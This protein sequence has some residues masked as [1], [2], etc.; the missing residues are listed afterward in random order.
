[1][2]DVEER[3]Q[4]VDGM[5]LARQGARQIEAEPIDVHLQN[6]VPQAV[7]D[8][9]KNPRTHHVQRISA[10]RVVHVE[11]RIVPDQ[12]VVRRVVQSAQRERRPQMI[13]LAG[14]VV[15]HVQNHFEARSVQF[16]HHVLKFADRA[17]K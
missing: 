9:L 16:S 10:A 12:P 3:P 17:G 11:P 8:Q 1:M 15:D 6:P 5:L 4:P 2:N 7:H 13:A 14:V